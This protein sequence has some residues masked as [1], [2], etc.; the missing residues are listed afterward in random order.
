MPASS[1]DWQCVQTWWHERLKIWS[2]ENRSMRLSVS[3][4]HRP[5][6]SRCSHSQNS[7][8]VSLWRGFQVVSKS[9]YK[10]FE[11]FRVYKTLLCPS[12]VH[13]LRLWVFLQLCRTWLDK[14]KWYSN[15]RYFIFICCFVS[16]SKLLKA[17]V[18]DKTKTNEVQILLRMII[19]HGKGEDEQ[20]KSQIQVHNAKWFDPCGVTTGISSSELLISSLLNTHITGLPWTDHVSPGTPIYSLLMACSSLS[21]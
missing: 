21:S 16:V 13:R 7:Q 17:K 18:K 19:Q 5:A 11:C 3:L 2:D 9:W 4:L 12:L 15:S 6:S 20:R 8:Q 1:F 10:C 14:K